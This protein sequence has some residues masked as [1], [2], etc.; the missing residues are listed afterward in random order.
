MRCLT[1]YQISEWAAYAA[2]EPFGNLQADFRA[3]QVCAT[4]ANVHRNSS[5]N[6]DPFRPD[7]FMP[8]LASPEAEQPVL[9]DD[10]EAQ[11]RL[12]MNALFKKE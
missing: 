1:S 3:G 12:L 11:S 8:A 10:T 4:V 5:R 2:I 7:D 9:L 6:P